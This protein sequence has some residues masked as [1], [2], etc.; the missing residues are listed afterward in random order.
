MM[1][2]LYNSLTLIDQEDSE[3]REEQDRRAELSPTSF[4]VYTECGTWVRKERRKMP[5]RRL[6]NINVCEDQLQE[7]EFTDLFKAFR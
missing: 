2:R 6:Q 3:R 1:G 4:P 7:D 5:E